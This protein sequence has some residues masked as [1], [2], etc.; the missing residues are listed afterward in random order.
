MDLGYKYQ[1]KWSLVMPWVIILPQAAA[2]IYFFFLL[3]STSRF[4]MALVKTVASKSNKSNIV[5]YVIIIRLTVSKIV[6][7]LLPTYYLMYQNN[8]ELSR[9]KY[10]VRNIAI[11]ARTMKFEISLTSEMRKCTNETLYKHQKYVFILSTTNWKTYVHRLSR[12][13]SISHKITNK[14]TYLLRAIYTE[15]LFHQVHRPY[16]IC[17]LFDFTIW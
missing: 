9:T 3:K 12:Q 11:L 15:F 13:C 10:E 4:K 14:T 6:I 17:Q 2:V 16:Q 8:V 1:L 7:V 5:S